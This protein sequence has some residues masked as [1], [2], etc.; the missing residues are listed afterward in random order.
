MTCGQGCLVA[1]RAGSGRG[2]AEVLT[3]RYSKT[4]SASRN[5]LGQRLV[6]VSLLSG[7]GLCAVP[8]ASIPGNRG[9][10]SWMCQFIKSINCFSAQQS[11]HCYTRSF[12]CTYPAVERHTPDVEQRDELQNRTRASHGAVPGLVQSDEVQPHEL[13]RVG[14]QFFQVSRV[15]QGLVNLYDDDRTSERIVGMRGQT[16]EAWHRRLAGQRRQCL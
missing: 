4:P 10:S 2:D 6:D 5:N 9:S 7:T 8:A 15:R 1:E 16:C 12:M 14:R 13:A 11:D 3:L